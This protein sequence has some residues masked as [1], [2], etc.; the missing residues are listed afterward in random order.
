[1]K[2][3]SARISRFA[4]TLATLGIMSSAGLAGSAAQAQPTVQ[5]EQGTVNGREDGAVSAFLGIPYA[6]APIGP[7]RWRAPQPAPQWRAPRDA[8][9]YGASCVQNVL[10]G[11][12]PPW[13][14]E[15]MV[16]GPV[17]EDCLTLNVWTPSADGA[18]RP[19][20]VWIHGGGFTEGS[21]SVPIYRGAALAGRDIVVVSINYRLGLYGFL[22]HPEITREAGN[23]VPTNFGMQDQIA[24][25]KWVKRNIAR[26]GGDPDQVTIAGQSA[27]S[28]AVH[29]LVLSPLAKG[30]FVR[31]VAESGLPSI[32]PMP[33][34]AQSEQNGLAFA[35]QVHATSLA[36]LRKMTP[37]QLTLPPP[38]TMMGGLRFGLTVDGKFLPDNPA[39]MLARGEFNDTPMIVGQNADEGSAFPG[40]GA[41]DV[42]AYQSFMARSFGDKAKDF[43]RLYPASTDAE[44]SE[45]VKAASRD[46]GLALIADWARTKVVKSKSPVWGYYYAH[47]EPGAGAA[48]FGTF[49]SSEIPYVFGTLDMA[50]ARNFTLAD[51]QLSLLMSSYWVNFVKT[52]NPNGTGLPA[53][54]PTAADA[55]TIVEFGPATVTERP[56]LTPE[57]MSAYDELIKSGGKLS[58]F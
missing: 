27:G 7:N 37:A 29:S 32:L 2:S 51:R 40:Y 53:W 52:G 3:R 55:Q 46:R 48:Q 8:T 24:A 33:T 28:M 13:T 14:A 57:K 23:G 36:Q 12:R 9:R 42:A 17:S 26:F 22:A 44:R 21:G 19:V 56:I 45:A 39:A 41:G 43:T 1:M 54:K 49:H 34:L 5:V 31:A 58:M 25:L 50:P 10:P 30:L 11:G 35:K 20:L 47:T 15:Y 18:K 38:T 16:Q 4:V 6:A